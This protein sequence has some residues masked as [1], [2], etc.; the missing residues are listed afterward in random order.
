MDEDKVRLD[1]LLVLNGLVRS[2]THAK[3]LIIKGQVICDQE[4][5]KKASK[6]VSR[7]SELKVID[8]SKEW[9]SRGGFKLIGAIEHFT[10]ELKNKICLDIGASTGGFTDVLLRGGV[11]KVY[12]V[13]VGSGQL[14]NKLRA[15]EIV[16]NLE[17]TDARNL[18]VTLI[19][20][21]IDI[22]VC[23]VSFISLTKILPVPM[24]LV[25]EGGILICLVKPQFE[26]GPG[27]VGKKG[28][29]RDDKLRRSILKSISLWFDARRGWRVL[30]SIESPILGASGNREFLVACWKEDNIV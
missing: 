24:R 14:A 27:Q 9:V 25:K 13:D 23:D 5:A 12:A 2:R 15:N 3:D 29:V 7:T 26:V 28:V 6:V 16:K 18:S 22:L 30:D 19:P 20:D 11:Q 17:K 21:P 4:V 1:Q 10:I 8:L